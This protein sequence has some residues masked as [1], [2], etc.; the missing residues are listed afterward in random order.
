M[1]RVTG[2]VRSRT[3]KGP[4]RLVPIP[5]PHP[6]YRPQLDWFARSGWLRA[7]LFTFT[8]DQGAAVKRTLPPSSP[9]P[10]PGTA[11]TRR[12]AHPA[13]PQLRW[14]DGAPWPAPPLPPLLSFFRCRGRP[15]S[16]ATC[17]V[18]RPPSAQRPH[19]GAS[20]GSL[21]RAKSKVRE[22]RRPAT[23][24]ATC[25]RGR[26]KSGLGWRRGGGGGG[27]SGTRWRA[28]RGGGHGSIVH[29]PH[30]PPM[31][32]EVRTGGEDEGRRPRS[33]CSCQ[34]RPFTLPGQGCSR[35]VIQRPELASPHT[36]R[37][38]CKSRGGGEHPP[39]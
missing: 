16:R 38:S 34:P 1:R 27:G 22:S 6:L 2:V 18:S 14:C 17:P 35:S 11:L 3:S 23:R 28:G 20:P 15:A 9:V 33:H 31:A 24:R 32:N 7:L 19:K 12:R 25:P 36:L 8:N 29:L 21:H 26:A 4:G 37:V 10:S 30:I 13:P 5:P 39:G